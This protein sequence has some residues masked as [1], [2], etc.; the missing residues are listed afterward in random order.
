M[1]VPA[2][3]TPSGTASCRWPSRRSPSHGG[4]ELLA[5]RNEVTS[6][7]DVGRIT[8]SVMQFPTTVIAVSNMVA[9]AVK[10]IGPSTLAPIAS[11]GRYPSAAIWITRPCGKLP[12][13]GTNPAPSA[14]HGIVIGATPPERTRRAPARS[15]QSFLRPLAIAL[16]PFPI[17]AI[18]LLPYRRNP[19]SLEPPSAWA[20]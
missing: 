6:P 13:S 16:S 3:T 11:A 12:S 7:A 18:I 10:L 19:E 1:A 5:I 8:G 17:V 15:V 14:S 9:P 2:S 4:V 20:G